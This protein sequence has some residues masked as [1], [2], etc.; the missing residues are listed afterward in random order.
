MQR[1][2]KSPQRGKTRRLRP[3]VAFLALIA[4]PLFCL[5]AGEPLSGDST[6]VNGDISA[7]TGQ[8][9]PA[10]SAGGSFLRRYENRDWYCQTPNI[11]TETCS[12]PAGYVA[13][14]VSYSEGPM[15][16]EWIEPSWYS[17]GYICER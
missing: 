3:L 7:H 11:H 17:Q 10:Q 12:C 4:L 8:A 14:L 13:R 9:S 2:R 16:N 1:D 5:N 6:Q 15:A